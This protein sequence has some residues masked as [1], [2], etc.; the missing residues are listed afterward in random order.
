MKEEQ[1]FQ[2]AD[3][4]NQIQDA[5][6][7]MLYFSSESCS[8]CRVLK[9]KVIS[10]VDSSFPRMKFFYIDIEKSPQLAGN[11][12]V[13]TIPTILVFFGGKE[14]FRKGRSFGIDELAKD[15]SRPY[16]LIFNE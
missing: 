13:F 1:L 3:V 16:D 12:R 5:P 2:I 4:E 6:A 11:F 9:P 7:V 10:L 15:I 8:V 14:F